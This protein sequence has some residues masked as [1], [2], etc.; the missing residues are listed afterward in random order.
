MTTPTPKPVVGYVRVSTE[1]QAR[2]GVSPEAQTAKIEAW[3]ALHDAPLAAIH[4]DL[5]ISGK[6]M[7]NRP[8]LQAAL[9]H[10]C[11]VKGVLVFYSL[12]RVSRSTKDTI[13]IGERIAKAGADLVSLSE[14]IDTTTAAGEWCSSCWPCSRSSSAT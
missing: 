7:D 10:V 9:D 13:G 4:K 6:C 3:C 14:Q 2:E 12:S 5:G 11:K 1:D 8:G